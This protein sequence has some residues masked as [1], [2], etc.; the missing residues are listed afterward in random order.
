MEADASVLSMPLGLEYHRKPSD[1]RIRW[2]RGVARSYVI[3]SVRS[4]ELN[5][6]TLEAFVLRYIPGYHQQILL[7][8]VAV[9][10]D[11]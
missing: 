5:W 6:S 7:L 3:S 4:L 1:K 9:D 8:L 11:L 2:V 10:Q